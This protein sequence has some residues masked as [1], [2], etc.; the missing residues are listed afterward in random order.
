MSR[1]LF[2]TWEGGGH[3]QPMLMAARGL[4]A[5][6]HATLTLSDA[7]NAPEAT[8]IGVPFQAWR[9]APSR[10]DRSPQTDPIKDWLAKTPLETIRGLTDGL[11][12]GPA[13]RY[14]ADA[15]A[16]IEAFRPDVVVTQEL[17][18]GVMA[19][20]ERAGLPLALFV[21]NVW[22]F[23]TLRE[24]PPFGGGLP[25]PATEFDFTFYG[26]VMAATRTAFQAGLPALNAAR[27]SIGLT[28]LADLFDQLA[29]ARQVLLATSRAFDFDLA[30]PDPFVHV[31][32]Y[33]ADPVWAPDWT[34]PWQPS[35]PPM[36]LA[37]FST[38]YQGQ[39]TALRHTIE[40]MGALDVRGIVT[41]GPV[42]EPVDF[43]APDNVVVTRAAP[44]S[45][46]FPILSAVVTHAGHAS[47]L[48]PLMAGLP[49]VC[50]PLGRDQADNAARVTGRGAGLRL[51]PDASASDI[52]SAIET[53]IGEPSY[54][55][56]AAAL[57]SRITA[58]ADARSAERELI[59]LVGAEP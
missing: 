45:R 30:L 7:C 20:A 38:M 18:F 28:P 55:A 44:H 50:I 22:P 47:A 43:P 12:C 52:A 15:L 41:L 56:A 1:F 39:D 33:L 46:L 42:L 36:V 21:A 26:S 2:A 32:P 25:A 57:G 6:G 19:A 35:G 31:G 59:A 17:L 11:M 37:S 8:A 5:A 53:V 51:L 9:T 40:A 16:A 27:E 34:P 13:A 24:A 58:D 3:V 49:L 54:R 23:P 10:Q 48:R 4:E 14:A 29:I